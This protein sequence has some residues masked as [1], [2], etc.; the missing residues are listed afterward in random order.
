MT[1][2]PA[3]KGLSSVGTITVCLS[4]IRAARECRRLGGVLGLPGGDGEI[5]PSPQAGHRQHG[6]ENDRENGAKTSGSGAVFRGF[7]HLPALH[8]HFS[9]GIR[10]QKNSRWW[11]LNPQ[12]RLYESRA[13]PLSYIGVRQSRILPYRHTRRKALAGSKNRNLAPR[14]RFTWA[15]RTGRL[16]GQ[17]RSCLSA[18]TTGRGCPVR[19]PLAENVFSPP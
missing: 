3:G 14:F 7:R 15:H 10:R 18:V 9:R 4:L 2:R 13:L 12:P 6:H 8:R 5:P 17:P 1:F 16:R 19:G 11:D